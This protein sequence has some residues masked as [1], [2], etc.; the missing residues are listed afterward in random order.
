MNKSGEKLLGGHLVD[1]GVI[2]ADQLALALEEQKQSG[3][4]LGLILL[5]SGFIS[6]QDMFSSAL[7]RYLD[8]E[9][10]RLKERVI[11]ADT[12]LRIPAQ[13]ASHYKAIPIDIQNDL[14]VLATPY[15][16]DHTIMEG[17]QL[18]WPGKMKLVMTPETDV[19]DAIRKYYG[20]GAE[21][22]DAMMGGEQ[23]V[24]GEHQGEQDLVELDSEA[25]IGKF[26]NQILLEAWHKRATDIHIE[27]FETELKIRYRIDGALADIDV[28]KNIFHFR[29]AIISRIKIMSNLNIAERRLPQDGR[30]KVRI[31]GVDLDLRVSF[32]PT[33][34]GESA[35]IRL[36]SSGKLYGLKE[37]GLS[38][39]HEQQMEQLIQKPHGIIFVTGPTGSG[40]T[41]TLYCCMSRVM[42]SDKKII[43]IEDPIEYLIRGV[44]Q[45][46]V[47]PRIGFTFAAGLRSMLRHDPD[48]MMVGEVR[49]LETAQ[50]AIQVALTGHLV[51]S[52]LHTNDAAGG[53]TRLL[54]M[55]VEP[56]L[57]SSAV[58]AFIAQRL[59]R[60]VCQ[61]CRKETHIPAGNLRELGFD[62]REDAIVSEGEGCE[63]CGFTG[64]HGR[65]GIFEFLK[66][67]EA[68]GE[69]ITQKAS[70][71]RIR[72]H[73][74]KLGM[75][76][77]M[78]DGWS[79]IQ[80]GV[81]TLSEVVR[82]TRDDPGSKF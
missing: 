3:K 33:P 41:T 13:F 20:L 39:E 51:F 65:Q 37:L 8:C 59:V 58:E 1:A 57:I 14:L 50:I 73:V 77:L 45:L 54:D 25:S 11:S 32:L 38:P 80:Q 70:A 17:L 21:T 10:V 46:Q 31:S 75:R 5:E 36:L 53:I 15:P 56:Y 76:S 52:T 63:V 22:I 48:I 49:D 82:V 19:A 16:T 69:L 68:V 26:L 23:A 30:F 34:N 44:T 61:N 47:N 71:A 81:T 2:S 67:D 6:D 43:T 29:D 18:I 72:E 7:S 74:C 66:V 40:K 78:Q 64:Y 27:P 62:V 24:K 4:L 12:I 28:P 9:F 79:K 55:G 60:K 42:N 35:V